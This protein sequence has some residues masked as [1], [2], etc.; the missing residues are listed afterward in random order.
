MVEES[1]VE[2]QLD[3]LTFDD[4]VDN[5]EKVSSLFLIATGK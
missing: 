4:I 5:P 3:K 1:G 2:K